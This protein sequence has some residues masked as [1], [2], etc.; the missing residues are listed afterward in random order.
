MT[1]IFVSEVDLAAL[2]QSPAQQ[3][4]AHEEQL[5]EQAEVQ[6]ARGPI[7]GIT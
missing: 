6:P 4:P 7:P 1:S 5:P 3:S 2:K